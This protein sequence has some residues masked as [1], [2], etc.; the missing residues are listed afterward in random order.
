M[1]DVLLAASAQTVRTLSLSS[2]GRLLL[3]EK[4]W[5]LSLFILDGKTG[6]DCQ[7][8]P[9]SC[10]ALPGSCQAADPDVGLLWH[11]KVVCF[12]CVQWLKEWEKGS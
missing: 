8:Q 7:E 4:S 12:C 1:R 5:P 2:L 3:Q 9:C 11:G 6:Q 10:C